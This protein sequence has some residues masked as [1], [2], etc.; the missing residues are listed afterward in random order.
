MRRVYALWV[1]KSLT[2]PIVL[3]SAILFA[4]FW[5]GRAY[6]SFADVLVNSP[7]I[8][9]VNDAS[10]LQFALGAVAHA[11]KAMYILAM[12]VA[13]TGLWLIRDISGERRFARSFAA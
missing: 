5:Q 10:M 9:T 8:N 4:L 3:K 1:M 12:L 2:S 7:L 13:L 6:I 11:D